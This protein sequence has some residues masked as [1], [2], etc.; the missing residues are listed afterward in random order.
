MI[1]NHKRLAVAVTLFTLAGIACAADGE[2]PRERFQRLDRN[3]DGH[4]S[5]WEKRF[6]RLDRN[7]DGIIGPRERAF[8][9][10][11]RNNDG[12]IGKWERRRAKR[13]ARRR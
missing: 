8:D 7:D 4:I 13:A 5:K 12:H 2:T 3:G 1:V 10:L 11:D 9:R 6:D